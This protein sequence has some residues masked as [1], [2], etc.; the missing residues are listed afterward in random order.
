MKNNYI[1]VTNSE[2]CGLLI[3]ANEYVR[4]MKVSPNRAGPGVN[5]DCSEVY[6]KAAEASR[7]IRELGL[8][9]RLIDEDSF[10]L[11]QP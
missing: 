6:R 8:E 4:V 3:L 5:V 7:S 10:Y 2:L 11:K 9:T 1:K